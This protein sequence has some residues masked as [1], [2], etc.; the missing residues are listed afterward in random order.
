MTALPAALIPF[1]TQSAFSLPQARNSQESV[2]QSSD[3]DKPVCYIETTDGT[4]LDLSSICGFNDK[5]N[6][7]QRQSQSIGRL[8][9]NPDACPDRVDSSLPPSPA[10]YIPSGSPY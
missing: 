2:V 7:Q 6:H 10:V 8:C 4:T 5:R 9:S 1:M 3:T